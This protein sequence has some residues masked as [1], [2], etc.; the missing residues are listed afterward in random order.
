MNTINPLRGAAAMA[1][2]TEI[3][4]YEEIREV[5]RSPVFHQGAYVQ[6]SSDFMHDCMT[7]LDGPRHFQRRRLVGQLFTE[8]S[9]AAYRDEHLHPVIALTLAEITS[10]RESDGSVRTDLVPLVWRMLYRMAGAITG[11]DGLDS[12]AATEDFIA[13]IRAMGEAVTVDWS[14][15]DSAAVLEN[16]RRQRQAFQEQFF[17]PSV[18]RRRAEIER[19]RADEV[20]A[21][22][23]P[24]DL[25]T[26]LLLHD[27]PTWDADLPLRESSVFLI[28]A[29][30]TTAQAFAPFILQL[31]NWLEGH[32]EDRAK[33]LGEPEFLTR[34]AM[35]SLRF[36][37]AAPARIRVA[38]EDITLSSGRRVSKG[39]RVALF[40]IPANTQSEHFGDEA[41][42]FDPHRDTQGN[43]RWGLAFGGGA[44]SCIGRPLVTGNARNQSDGTMVSIA[45]RLYELGMELDPERQPVA[46]EGTYYYQLSSLPVR[47]TRLPG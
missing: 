43:P 14:R 20:T 7:M 37:V 2:V 46:D 10:Q 16:G 45:R 19:F 6:S 35:E 9:L 47:F 30:Q 13:M 4:D 22:E 34:A 39:E 3:S 23:L 31:E 25:L 15:R 18:R 26:L 38:T 36:F 41:E 21:D 24:R 12:S 27:D 32:P 29:T 44:H 11:I 5:L 33:V 1:N 28:A 40:F 17:D 42:S 8:A